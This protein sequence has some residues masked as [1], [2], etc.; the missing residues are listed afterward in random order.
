MF[1]KIVP[2]N[3]QT[4]AGL[5]VKPVDDF[6][7]ARNAHIASLVV[8]EFNRVV[9]IFPIVFLKEDEGKFGVYALLG[10][11]QGHNL[12][13]DEDGKWTAGYVPAIIR[14]YPFALGKG[15][16]EGQ[17]LICLDEESEFV[18]RNEGESLV[19]E[20]GK[21]GKIVE[22]AKEYLS[23]L[24]R[25]SE[26]TARFCRDIVD[27]DLLSPLN[28]QVSVAGGAPQTISGCFGVDEKKLNELGDD[29]YLELKRR[30]ALPLIYAHI[31]SLG[32]LEKL[33]KMQQEQ[34]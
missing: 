18:S 31:F 22:N 15:S 6:G 7:F 28:M 8:G 29:A 4:H 3:T 23:E 14:R 21:P 13:V 26:L 30:A 34:G 12:F 10:L 5:R 25:M 16:T 9:P 20:S 2:F 33:A 27:R 24:Y 32:N 19:D 11:R 1:K 17:F